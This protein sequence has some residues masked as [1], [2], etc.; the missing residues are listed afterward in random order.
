V[1]LRLQGS[2]A[3]VHWSR[4]AFNGLAEVIVQASREPGT[5]RLVAKADGLAA[6]SF[7]LKAQP[8]APR[9]FVP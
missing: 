3:P 8:A 6:A 1:T 2:P 5:I 4:S 9:P 7:A